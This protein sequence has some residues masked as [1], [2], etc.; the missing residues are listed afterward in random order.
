M[1]KSNLGKFFLITALF[2]IAPCNEAQGA[3][4]VIFKCN[5]DVPT[6]IELVI[7]K[8]GN[9]FYLAEFTI[10]VAP[11]ID[12]ADFKA[13]EK[14]SYHR[15]LVTEHSLAFSEGKSEV[16]VSD[17]YSEEF[18]TVTKKKTVTLQK[19]DIKKYWACD[20]TAIS[21]LASIDDF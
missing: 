1:I 6:P 19:N 2:F 4:Q 3:S 7:N 13:V 14:S 16:I 17:Y 8:V 10:N 9:K 21:K 15:S 20:S 5:A 11:V 12:S 18:D